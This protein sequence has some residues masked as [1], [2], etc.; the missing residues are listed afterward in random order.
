MKEALLQQ[1]PFNDGFKKGSMT[2][3]KMFVLLGCI[4]KAPALKQPLYDC[5]VHFQCAFD[6]VNKDMMFTN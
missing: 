6:N 5:F 3:D 1:D 4:R 2:S